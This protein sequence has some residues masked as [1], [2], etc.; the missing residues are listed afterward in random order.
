MDKKLRLQIITPERQVLGREVDFVAMPAHEGEMGVLYRH[1]SFVVQLKEGILRYKSGQEEE[2]FAISG[3]FVEINNNEVSVFA[4]AAEFAEEI[5]TER[6]R[7]ALQLA[8]NTIVSGGK[9]MNINSAQAAI[10]R[11]AARMKVAGM[12]RARKDRRGNFPQNA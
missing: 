4:E 8:K 12:K 10:R 11:A 6:A 9:D 2:V 1:I 3:G 5:D 7:Q